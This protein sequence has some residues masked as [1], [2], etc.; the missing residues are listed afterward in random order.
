MLLPKNIIIV[1]DEPITQMYLQNILDNYSIVV[2]GCFHNADDLLDIID[3]IQTD[4]ILMDINIKGSI[5]GIQ[6]AKKILSKYKIPIIFITAYKDD[7]TIQEVLELSPYGFI[8][9]PFQSK[10]IYIAI[11][12][13]YQQF[14]KEKK[15]IDK[16]CHYIIINKYFKFSQNTNR[17]YYED[18]SIKLTP[19]QNKLIKL[20]AQ[21][22]NI[23][24]SIEQIMIEVWGDEEYAD[25]S[26]RTLIYSIRKK[27]PSLPIKSSPKRGYYLSNSI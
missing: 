8:N 23:T 2:D 5:D 22:L 19:K 18:N 25:N 20:L 9:K 11:S 7:N 24:V 10:D 26:L 13:G 27:I 15:S 14:I 17:L 21:N 12:I 6:L 16:E 3:T 1:E 4:M